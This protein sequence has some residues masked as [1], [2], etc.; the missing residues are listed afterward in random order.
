MP[1]EIQEQ[2]LIAKS[3]AKQIEKKLTVEQCI[4]LQKKILGEDNQY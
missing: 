1:Y 2:K 4:E 3:A